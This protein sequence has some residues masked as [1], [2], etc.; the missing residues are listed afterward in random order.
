[1]KPGKRKIWSAVT[2]D[3]VGE[4][5]LSRGFAALM[6]GEPVAHR[7]GGFAFAATPLIGGVAATEKENFS[8]KAEPFRTSKRRS[9]EMHIP[10]EFAS[11]IPGRRTAK[12]RNKDDTKTLFR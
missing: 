12:A 2:C 1:M 10:N 7:G 5:F 4:L 11:S 9:R 3:T 8:G 6:C